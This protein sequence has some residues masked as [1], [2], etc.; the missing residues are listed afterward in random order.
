MRYPR[1]YLVYP[2]L[3]LARA[4][5]SLW[6]ISFDMQLHLKNRLLWESV[7]VPLTS[8]SASSFPS[9]PEWPGIH[10]TL[11]SPPPSCIC[12]ITFCMTGFLLL[13]WI[14]QMV[15]VYTIRLHCS[16]HLFLPW[17]RLCRLAQSHRI[18]PSVVVESFAELRAALGRSRNERACFSRIFTSDLIPATFRIS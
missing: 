10:Y 6:L 4:T 9:M 16:R 14:A 5:F 13:F 11:I 17:T 12:L 1:V 3:N 2:N 18:W 7:V 8:W 15:P